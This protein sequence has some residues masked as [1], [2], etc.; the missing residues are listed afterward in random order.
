MF[1]QSQRRTLSDNLATSPK[2]EPA[3]AYMTVP[4]T[5]KAEQST[6]PAMRY[7]AKRAVKNTGALNFRTAISKDQASLRMAPMLPTAGGLRKK[8]RSMDAAGRSSRALIKVLA[9]ARY[10]QI[11]LTHTR[12][13][14]AAG[15][16]CL[17]GALVVQ[18]VCMAPGS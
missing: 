5:P 1:R 4:A 8:F 2:I 11:G 17:R 16:T 18:T 15:S 9:R 7:S 13:P 6:A 12:F 3:M 14:P 10:V